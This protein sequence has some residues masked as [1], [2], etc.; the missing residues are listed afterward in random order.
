MY[1]RN[2]KSPLETQYQTSVE[3]NI[4]KNK[5]QIPLYINICFMYESWVE[6][7]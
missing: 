3:V 6:E 2:E 7:R 1:S 4:G 5:I